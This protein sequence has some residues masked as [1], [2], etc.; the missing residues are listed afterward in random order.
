MRGKL[1]FINI[2][3]II[4]LGF[5][6]P[7]STSIGSIISS[8][9]FLLWLIDG[10]FKYKL[11]KIIENRA[12][13]S[14]ILLFSIY[15]LGLLY[16][17]DLENGLY[18]LKKGRYLLLTPL[19]YTI[20][21]N[22]KVRKR[23]INSFIAGVICSV[24]ISYLIYFKILKFNN[25]T[26]SCPTIIH[27]GHYSIHLAFAIFYLLNSFFKNHSTY[28]KITI[29]LIIIL[30]SINL[31]IQYGRVGQLAFFVLMIFFAIKRYGSKGILYGIIIL[32]VLST[33]IYKISPTFRMRINFAIEDITQF[34]I[35]EDRTGVG[36]RLIFWQNTFKI[37]KANPIIGVG[38][39]DFNVEHEKIKQP[40]DKPSDNPHNNYLFILTLFGVIGFIIFLNLFYQMFRY[41]FLSPN[42]E[43]IQLLIITMLIFMFF[44]S[45]LM[46]HGMLFFTY[47]SGLVLN[48][49]KR[50]G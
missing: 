24:F 22:E 7:L 38:T 20:I 12:V 18:I 9:I 28:L 27:Y 3:L 19:I 44:N 30:M 45:P 11:N 17:T 15:A 23:A 4:L 32:C 2:Y 36:I 35:K 40:G 8:L 26:P 31:F 33:C 49:E 43:I 41:S 21:N 1:H 42:G 46:R 39:G 50:R 13:L 25:I 29:L 47:L 6:I 16:T 5:F 10:N 37:I 34:K 14:F 48:Y